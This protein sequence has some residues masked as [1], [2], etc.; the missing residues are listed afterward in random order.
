[1]CYINVNIVYLDIAHKHTFLSSYCSFV[2]VNCLSK[3][4]HPFEDDIIHRKGL[5]I[6]IDELLS[7]T[8]H[9]DSLLLRHYYILHMHV[10]INKNLKKHNLSYMM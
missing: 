8:C 7:L 9:I 4:N 10:H 2:S 5:Q 3:T 1:M 6:E